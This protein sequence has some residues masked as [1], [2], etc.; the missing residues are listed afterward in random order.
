[1][2]YVISEIARRAS[3]AGV[4][5]ITYLLNN[6]SEEELKDLRNVISQELDARQLQTD[7]QDTESN[8][9]DVKNEPTEL[10]EKEVENL[11]LDIYIELGI[12]MAEDAEDV[13]LFEEEM[14]EA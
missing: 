8:A 11:M 5:P 12:W 4:T 2:R 13:G 7:V 10:N 9:P 6:F 3:D 1:M 14:A